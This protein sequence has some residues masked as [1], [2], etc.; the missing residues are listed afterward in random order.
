MY[1]RNQNG[2]ERNMN[3]KSLRCSYF[4][5]KIN[6]VGVLVSSTL[7]NNIIQVGRCHD[8]IILTKENSR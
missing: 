6:D 1:S 5:K 3:K 4:E 2:K 8:R 7:K